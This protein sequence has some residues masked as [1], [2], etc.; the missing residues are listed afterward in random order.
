MS[1]KF[2]FGLGSRDLFPEERPLID[3]VFEAVK[4]GSAGGQFGNI[5]IFETEVFDSEHSSEKAGTSGAARSKPSSQKGSHSKGA[6]AA[7]SA[8][9]NSSAA[10]AAG[11]DLD[12]SKPGANRQY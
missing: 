5:K 10:E 1:T 2:T 7:G 12:Y 6:S 8:S 3:F 4:A 9:G 11:M